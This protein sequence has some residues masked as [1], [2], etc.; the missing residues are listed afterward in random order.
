[1]ENDTSSNFAWGIVGALLGAGTMYVL[2]KEDV[3]RPNPVE[4]E[5]YYTGPLNDN[6]GYA[7][8]EVTADYEIERVLR[9]QGD[10][11]WKALEACTWVSVFD[12]PEDAEVR[13]T[14]VLRD[15]LYLGEP[16]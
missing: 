15:R 3:Y 6:Y 16:D 7:P 11:M 13:D 8:D 12:L 1:M 2:A 5:V 9:L 10:A 14:Y 4:A